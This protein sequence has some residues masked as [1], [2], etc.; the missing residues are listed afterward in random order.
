MFRLERARA[1]LSKS[2]T[3]SNNCLHNSAIARTIETPGLQYYRHSLGR[4]SA[5]Y[6]WLRA[7]EQTEYVR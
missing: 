7:C 6:A 2:C 3:V 4:G 1:A 5:L